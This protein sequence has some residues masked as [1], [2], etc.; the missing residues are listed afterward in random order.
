MNRRIDA[1]KWIAFLAAACLMLSAAGLAEDMSALQKANWHKKA[2][3]KLPEV[4]GPGKIIYQPLPRAGES[5][6]QELEDITF[7]YRYT[8]DYKE[9]QF[10]CSDMSMSLW[11]LLKRQGYDAKLVINVSQPHMWVGVERDGLWAMIETTAAPKR[12]LGITADSPEYFSH[13]WIFNTSAE[14]ALFTDDK[15]PL[16]ISQNRSLPVEEIDMRSRMI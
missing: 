13:C 9:N 4:Y 2:Y 1:L 6:R 3:S 8:K 12:A 14:A 15:L 10:D 16:L 5:L 11:Y 7:N